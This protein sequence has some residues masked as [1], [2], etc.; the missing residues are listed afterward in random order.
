M[1]WNLRSVKFEV[2]Q[3]YIVI[4][5][6]LSQVKEIVTIGPDKQKVLE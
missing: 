4:I 6:K 5:S 2:Q 3:S 1:V